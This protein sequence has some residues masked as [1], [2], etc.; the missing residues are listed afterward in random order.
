MRKEILYFLAFIVIAITACNPLEDTYN[1]LD[2]L[3]KTEP[4]TLTL[5]DVQYKILPSSSAPYKQLYFSTE[6]EAKANIPTILNALYS[7]YSDGASATVNYTV[8]GNVVS[9]RTSYTL[10]ATDYTNMGFSNSRINVTNGDNDVLAF[11]NTKY[12]A[13][14]ENQLVILTY[15]AYNSN[16]STTASA[17][18]DSYYYVNGKWVNAYHVSP[19]DYAATGAARFN[20]YTSA[21]KPNLG[22]Y[23]NRFLLANISGAKTNDIQYVSYYIFDNSTTP[24]VTEQRIMAMYYDGTRWRPVTSNAVITSSQ[25]FVKSNG[26][27]IV[28]PTINYTLVTADYVT[29]SNIS[30]VGT[31]SNRSNLGSF[32]NF[33]VSPSGTTV[34]SDAE[35]TAALAAFLKIK[36]PD[37]PVDQRYRV[38]YYAYRSGVYSY[39]VKVFK[40]LGSGE[41]ELQEK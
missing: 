36:Y 12:P 40:K 24:S 10:T 33:N 17:V 22:D 13:P 15:N 32:K 35:V 27:W 26:T 11:L 28:D 18:T 16:M 4:F 21:D 37:A 8:A 2:Q 30:T 5:G 3:P 20:D 1:Q 6:T 34:W 7:N 31:A 25:G 19:A 23:F 9:S 39:P 38:T 14:T 29:I 41:F